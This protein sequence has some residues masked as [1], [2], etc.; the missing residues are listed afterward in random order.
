MGGNR[1]QDWIGRKGEVI[2]SEFSVSEA[3]IA[4]FSEFSENGRPDYFGSDPIA[5]PTMLMTATRGSAWRP[6]QEV[7]VPYYFALDVPLDAPHSINLSIEFEFGKPLRP[8]DRVSRQSTIADIVPKT[9]RLGDGF[10]VVE[11]IDYWNQNG[12]RLGRLTNSLFRYTKKEAV[13]A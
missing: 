5:P 12:E 1:W 10:I 2:E 4:Y 9:L 7:A 6:G 3:S 8:G 13:R 11:H